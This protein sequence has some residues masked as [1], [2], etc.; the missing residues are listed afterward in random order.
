MSQGRG[1]RF[2]PLGTQHKYTLCLVAA[3]RAKGCKCTGLQSKSTMTRRDARRCVRARARQPT[4]AAKMAAPTQLVVVRHTHTLSGM[5][6][7][8]ASGC[9]LV[10][11]CS[12]HRTTC[13]MCGC[14]A[15]SLQTQAT[16]FSAPRFR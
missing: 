14:N 10:S 5:T 8:A 7:E 1:S 12:L 16:C 4:A 15:G 13:G 3:E 11:A 2:L 9:V 6:V